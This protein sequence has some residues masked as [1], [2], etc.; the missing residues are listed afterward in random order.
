MTLYNNDLYNN[1]NRETFFVAEKSFVISLTESL[2]HRLTLWL[3]FLTINLT[4][5]C[6]VDCTSTMSKFTTRSNLEKSPPGDF[7]C[8][9]P[10]KLGAVKQYFHDLLL[11][12][13]FILLKRK[14]VRVLVLSKLPWKHFMTLGRLVGNR[15]T[16][17]GSTFK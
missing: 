8:S 17:L 4:I 6:W 1:S 12:F 13:I 14:N 7:L 3:L 5:F 10:S 16:Y 9:F 11:H 15:G 2:T